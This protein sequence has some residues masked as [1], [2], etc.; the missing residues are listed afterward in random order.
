MVEGVASSQRGNSNT[1]VN[2]AVDVVVQLA[3]SI[4]QKGSVRAEH[5]VGPVA[6]GLP[7]DNV[8]PT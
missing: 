1:C 5:G 6:H 2:A 4:Q 8:E 3:E 7:E